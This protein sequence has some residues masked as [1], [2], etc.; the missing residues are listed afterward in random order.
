MLKL[1]NLF[2][3]KLLQPKIIAILNSIKQGIN[4]GHFICFSMAKRKTGKH[5]RIA[6]QHAARRKRKK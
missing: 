2:K 3:I 4:L 1:I 6:D 5:A